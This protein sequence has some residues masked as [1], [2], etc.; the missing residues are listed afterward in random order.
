MSKKQRFGTW[1]VRIGTKLRGFS[2]RFGTND[3]CEIDGDICG[4]CRNC[5]SPTQTTNNICW[6]CDLAFRGYKKEA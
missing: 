6:R 2:D 1:L 5:G 4:V 3:Y